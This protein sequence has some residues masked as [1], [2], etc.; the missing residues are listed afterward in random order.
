MKMP[1]AFS[2]FVVWQ[3]GGDPVDLTTVA[4]FVHGVKN[5]LDVIRRGVVTPISNK[6]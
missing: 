5:P 6:A 3:C 1:W 2:F 4:K